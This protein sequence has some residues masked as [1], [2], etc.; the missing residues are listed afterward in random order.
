MN[1]N[2]STA[3][4]TGGTS[5]IGRAVAN[6]LAAQ[7]IHVVVA[8]RNA[9][10]GEQTVAAIRAAGGKA[11]FVKTD[12][13]DA[14]SA[15]SLAKRAVELGNGRVDILVNN[16]GIFPLGPTHETTE[17]DFERTYALNVK[18]PYFLVA[19]L[20]PLM[21]E[22]GKGAIVNIST[23]LADYGMSGMSLYGSSKA[24]INLLTKAWAAEYGPS[25]VRV[26]TVSPGPTRTEGTDAMGEGLD[27]LA[28]Q[29]PA[30]RPASADEIAE[31]VVFLATDRASFIHGANLAVDGGQTAV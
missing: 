8:G 6:Q 19:E 16:A 11:D 25:G 18:A 29:A 12:L 20:A 4:I 28:A 1:S 30:G 3:L 13:R 24:A 27:Q 7:G 31:A 23:M 14:S 2:Q 21:A 15:R 22:S 9:D 26:N 17:D 10:R 5:G